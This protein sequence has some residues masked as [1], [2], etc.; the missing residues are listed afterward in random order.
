MFVCIRKN[1]IQTKNIFRN[2]WRKIGLMIPKS[3]IFPLNR[4]PFL[5]LYHS[6]LFWLHFSISVL[7]AYKW[8]FETRSKSSLFNRLIE[9]DLSSVSLRNDFHEQLVESRWKTYGSIILQLC[10][11]SFFIQQCDHCIFRFSYFFILET[12]IK[13]TR[14]WI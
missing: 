8:L 3:T 4:E 14:Y 10:Y 7:N 9:V 2:K 11:V 6:I 1:S 12:L 5:G 13:Q